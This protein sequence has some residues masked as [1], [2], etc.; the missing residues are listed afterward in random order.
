MIAGN[1]GIR[2]VLNR[3]LAVIAIA[4][5]GWSGSWKKRESRFWSRFSE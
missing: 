1:A 3:G 4:R 2:M 5:S